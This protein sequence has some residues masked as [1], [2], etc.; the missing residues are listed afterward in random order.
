MFLA[1]AFDFFMHEVT[2]Y[3]L[4]QIDLRSWRPTQ[5]YR[6][7][8]VPLKRVEEAL[9]A[10]RNDLDWFLEYTNGFFCNKTMIAFEPV[11][12]QL[13]L[14]GVDVRELAD[15]AFYERGCTE[16]TLVKLKRRL[17]ELFSRRNLIA[18]QTDRSHADAQITSIEREIV[19][20]FIAD[21][22]K[23]VAGISNL[24]Q[25]QSRGGD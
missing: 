25:A 12:A 17:N 15:Q 10:G 13:N 20:T 9:Q 5:R 4:M 23:I 6:N 3:G 19:E 11:K 18:H 16:K 2:K 14:L 24:I 7:L 8:S 22:K 1:A 21:I